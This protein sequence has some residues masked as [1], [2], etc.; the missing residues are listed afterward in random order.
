MFQ[1]DIP[2]EESVDDILKNA[3]QGES[4]AFMRYMSFAQQAEDEGYP[5]I[6]KVFRTAAK[7]ERVHALNQMAAQGW[8][9]S[10]EENLEEA[11][12]G[13][14]D[15]CTNLYPRFVKVARD[16]GRAEAV[17][18]LQWVKQ[19]EKNHKEMFEDTLEKLKSEKEVEDKDYY[20][21]M[22]CGYAE[23]NSAPSSCPVCGA[24][25]KVFE[26]VE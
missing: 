24:P 13:E 3:F 12:E 10:T 1:C 8:L 15:E 20:V 11:I 2:E 16:E 14:T 22:N 19:V 9:P 7:G 4:M 5:G 21:C 26:K 23:P 18:S 6:A 17:T 25:K